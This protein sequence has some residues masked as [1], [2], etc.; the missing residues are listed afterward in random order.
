MQANPVF[1]GACVVF[2]LG[3]AVGGANVGTTPITRAGDSLGSIP[4]HS[5]VPPGPEVQRRIIAPRDQYALQTPQ[6]EVAVDD[7][8]W[9]GRWRG[10]RMARS[11]A[12]AEYEF[13]VPAY[14]ELDYTTYRAPPLPQEP[15]DRASADSSDPL[16]AGYSSAA[17]TQ[18]PQD[19]N[20]AATQFAPHPAASDPQ[21]QTDS[22]SSHGNARLI[23]VAAT[24]AARD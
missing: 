18:R 22:S 9:H 23:D 24:L 19:E 16:R 11:Y 6:G 1:L 17:R 15:A 14:E 10:T 2:A 5:F 8:A 12:S 7:L 20:E 4:Q 3:G 13:A 21:K